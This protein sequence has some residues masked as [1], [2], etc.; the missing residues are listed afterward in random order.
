MGCKDMLLRKRGCLHT[1]LHQ[2]CHSGCDPIGPG[3]TGDLITL[4]YCNLA[5]T[6]RGLWR[7]ATR[8]ESGAKVELCGLTHGLLFQKE[9]THVKLKLI[10]QL[11]W[12]MNLSYHWNLITILA[13][14]LT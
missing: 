8:G 14:S 2:P 4:E 13:L 7:M 11:V 10:V 5:G 1:G 9:P 12:Y 6:I 3:V